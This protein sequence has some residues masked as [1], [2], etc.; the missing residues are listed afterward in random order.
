V[1]TAEDEVGAVAEVAEIVKKRCQIKMNLTHNLI[2][3]LKAR[4][5]D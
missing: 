4:I 5:T 2:A 1:V 3:L